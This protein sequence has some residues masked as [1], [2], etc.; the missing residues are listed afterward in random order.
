MNCQKPIFAII[1]LKRCRGVLG[2][3]PNCTPGL[4]HI[5]CSKIYHLRFDYLPP[6]PE[7][8]KQFSSSLINA[9]SVYLYKPRVE[10]YDNLW[11]VRWYL[12]I[13]RVKSSI[14]YVN[15]HERS[16]NSL[17]ATT[18]FYLVSTSPFFFIIHLLR[19]KHY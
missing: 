8:L 16:S 12:T 7:A 5:F 6:I 10:F 13:N 11:R 18:L 1:L 17:R 19:M 14:I 15:S 4:P 3:T 9:R 2:L